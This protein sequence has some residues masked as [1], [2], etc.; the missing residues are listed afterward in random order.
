MLHGYKDPTNAKAIIL[1]DSNTSS[2]PQGG[3]GKS[4]LIEGLREIKN[5]LVIEDG[6]RLNTKG[7][8]EWVQ[9][10]RNTKIVAVDDIREK[11]NFQDLFSMITND[12]II[13]LKGVDK[14]SFPFK[15]SPKFILSTNYAIIGSGESYERRVM[16]F[17]L[18]D[19]YNQQNTPRTKYGREFFNG[20]DKDQWEL[21]DNLMVQ[22]IQSF[23]KKGLIKAKSI[24]IKYR[25]ALQATNEEF[26]EYFKSNIKVEKEYHLTRQ[27]LQFIRDYKEYDYIK[28]NTFTKWLKEYSIIMFGVNLN[29]RKSGSDKYF[30]I[31]G[32]ESNNDAIKS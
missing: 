24:N 27:F 1:M 18:S 23:L 19:H 26:M 7:R 4:L 9:I 25:K 28:Q 6:K 29:I 2:N 3:T 17:E 20:W 32:K 5:N 31:K 14:F 11:F 22:S 12:L 8:F 21:F 30:K 15:K 16:E 10:K 13:E